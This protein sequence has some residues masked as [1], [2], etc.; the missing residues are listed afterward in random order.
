MNTS[1][2]RQDLHKWITTESTHLETEITT[3]DNIGYVVADVSSYLNS[4]TL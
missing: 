1:S 3:N 2:K 4:G